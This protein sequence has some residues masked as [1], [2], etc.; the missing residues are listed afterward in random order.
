MII[1]DKFNPPKFDEMINQVV[2]GDCVEVMKTMPENCVDITI[3]SPPYNISTSCRGS[4]YD[5]Y[6]DNLHQDEYYTFICDV[7]IQLIK[8]NK[9]Y[10]FFNFQILKDNK[11]AYLKILERFSLNIKEIIIWH[12]AQ[13]QPAVQE[14]CLS[15]AFEFVVVFAKQENAVNRSFGHAFFNNRLKGQLNT[16]VIYGKNASNSMKNTDN[17]A[18]FPEYLPMWF[19]EKFSQKDDIIFDPFL[20]SGTTAS[21]AKQVGRKY[22]GVELSQIYA[23]SCRRRLSQEYLF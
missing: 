3:T 22:V 14:T 17:K 5:G 21:C 6:K 13:V 23:E 18:T 10:T 2:C 7:I 1:F 8:I 11:L 16:N 9:Y 19:I 12:K 4:M 20:G 15:S